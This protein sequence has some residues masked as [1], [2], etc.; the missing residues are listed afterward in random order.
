MSGKRQY[1]HIIDFDPKDSFGLPWGINQNF[2]IHYKRHLQFIVWPKIWKSFK[3][4]DVENRRNVDPCEKCSDDFFK[5]RG[6][7]CLENID[8]DPVDH[9]PERCLICENINITNYCKAI[10]G[11]K[12]FDFEPKISKN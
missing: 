7:E 4:I 11:E 12:N 5:N 3:F 2:C 1:H 10:K 9:L 6:C 8:C